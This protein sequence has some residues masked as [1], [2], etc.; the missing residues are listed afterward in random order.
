MQL[1]LIR[2]MRLGLIIISGAAIKLILR[3]GSS[4][5]NS[6]LMLGF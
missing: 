4:N 3:D 5:T 1:K 6:F 2:P